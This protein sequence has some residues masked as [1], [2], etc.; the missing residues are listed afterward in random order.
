[1]AGAAAGALV[2][3]GATVWLMTPQYAATVKMYVNNSA[4]VGTSI[5]SSD[6]TASKSLVETYI[7]II[8]SDAVLEDARDAGRLPY[9]TAQLNKMLTAG[10][11]NA[12]EVFYI[13]I[14]NPDPAQA[15]HIANAIADASPRRLSEIVEGSSLK[16]V[17]RAKIPEKPSTPNRIQN[18]AIGAALGLLIPAGGLALAAALDTRIADESDLMGITELPVLGTITDFTQAGKGGYGYTRVNASGGSEV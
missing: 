18:T 2:A 14:T 17:D 9:T 11:L 5:T 6:I 16:I 8:R 15:A 3:L 7:T 10:A 12:T 4:E 1:M 13:T